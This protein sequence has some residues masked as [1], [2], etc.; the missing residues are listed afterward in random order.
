MKRRRPRAATHGYGRPD[1]VGRRIDDGEGVVLEVR[2]Q[3]E[4][5]RAQATIV[6]RN[7]ELKKA[8]EQALAERQKALAG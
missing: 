4:K 6:W 7:D 3:N 1:R 5:L 8:Y 2:D